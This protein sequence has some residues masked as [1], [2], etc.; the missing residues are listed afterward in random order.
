[1]QNDN[2]TELPT[3]AALVTEA[4]GSHR[5][6][7]TSRLNL[8]VGDVVLLALATLD[9]VGFG[10]TGQRH[11]SI[12]DRFFGEFL[13]QLFHFGTRHFLSIKAKMN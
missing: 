7:R 5:F 9:Q 10:A 8:V 3:F 1:M 4:K 11:L 2:L 12:V 6:V 13:P